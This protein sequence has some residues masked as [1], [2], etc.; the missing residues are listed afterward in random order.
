MLNQ[1]FVADLLLLRYRALF[2]VGCCCT[3]VGQTVVN[4][5]GVDREKE[6]IPQLIQ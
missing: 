5:A 1:Q 4:I 3:D 2:V 6:M